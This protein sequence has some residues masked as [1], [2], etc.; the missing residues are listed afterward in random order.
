MTGDDRTEDGMR[1]IRESVMQEIG[2]LQGRLGLDRVILVLEEG[3]VVPSNFD[4]ICLQ[5]KHGQISSIFDRLA[6]ELK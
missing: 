5:F 4:G 6:G 3:P 1:L 2:Y